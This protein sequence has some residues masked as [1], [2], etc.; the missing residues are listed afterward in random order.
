MWSTSQS[1]LLSRLCLSSWFLLLSSSWTNCEKV[2]SEEPFPA[3]YLFSWGALSKAGLMLADF[4]GLHHVSIGVAELAS[5]GLEVGSL[6][7]CCGW[8]PGADFQPKTGDISV[9]WGKVHWLGRWRK[10]TKHIR[11]IITF[12]PTPPPH[13][14]TNDWHF[15]RLCAD[16]NY[17]LNDGLSWQW[18]CVWH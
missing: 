16:I 14:C 9:P 13:S 10:W 17:H 1:N 6:C 5:Y 18:I 15:K 7:E 8:R 12:I 4:R 2:R 3:N 11:W